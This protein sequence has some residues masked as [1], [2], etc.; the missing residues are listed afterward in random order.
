E[1]TKQDD[2]VQDCTIDTDQEILIPDSYVESITERLALY[3]R[4][5]NCENEEELVAMEEEFRDRFGPIPPQVQ[6][7]F[8]TV[9]VRKLAVNLGFEKLL[10]RDSS[11]KCYFIN[12]P[13]SPY[14]ESDL[15][16]RILDF[17]QTGT[18]KARLKQVGRVFLL[19]AE[20]MRTMVEVH[21]FLKHMHGKV[22]Q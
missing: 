10:L 12:R 11:L 22:V 4:L 2:Y 15:F 7:L 21:D 13:D 20:P 3:S 14:F 8:M 6:D 16:K 18:N 5:D 17:L 1:I 19:V 9:R